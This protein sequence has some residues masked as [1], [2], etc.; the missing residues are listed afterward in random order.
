V[1]IYMTRVFVFGSNLAGRHGAG[2]A[3]TARAVY[4]AQYGV[5][6]G[7]TGS[8]YAIPTKDAHLKVLPLDQ[9]AGHVKAFIEYARLHEELSFDVVAIGCGLAG[10]RPKQIAPMFEG[11]PDN[12][13]LP[14]EFL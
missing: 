6:V 4:G 1:E 13:H 12:V 3:K 10:F 7:P 2:S 14:E 8:S 5:G 11:A 9:I